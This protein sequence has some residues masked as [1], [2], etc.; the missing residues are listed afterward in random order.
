[1]ASSLQL[2]CDGLH[3]SIAMKMHEDMLNVLTQM[4]C[5]RCYEFSISYSMLVCPSLLPG[6]N[7]SSVAYYIY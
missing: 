2:N 6:F 3:P 7:L 1:M 5:V 4:S